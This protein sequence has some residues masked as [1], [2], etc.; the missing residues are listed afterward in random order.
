MTVS[1]AAESMSELISAQRTE[2]AWAGGAAHLPLAD[3]FGNG[4][5]ALLVIGLVVGLVGFWAASRFAPKGTVLAIAASIYIASWLIAPGDSR[6]LNGV[7][8]FMRLLGFVGGVL[9]VID[10]VRKRPT[11]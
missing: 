9:G 8:G 2:L 4:L 11:T 7:V 1:R 6:A 5:I 10:L 3:A